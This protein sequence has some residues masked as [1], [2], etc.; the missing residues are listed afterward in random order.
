MEEREWIERAR[1]GDPQAFSALVEL[2]QSPVFNLCYRMLNNPSDADD[3]AQE[4]F[5]KAYR[6]LAKYDQ[7]RSFLTWLLSIAAHHCIDQLRRKRFQWISL[8]ALGHQPAESESPEA[9]VER[10]QRGR[11]LENALMALRPA[12]R[13]VIVLS[14]WYDLSQAEIGELLSVTPSAVKSRMHRAKRQLSAHYRAE[15]LAPAPAGGPGGRGN[16]QHTS[17]GSNET[18]QV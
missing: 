3:A 16:P 12:D 2:Y 9:A 1:G 13:A 7:R 5:I 6:G 4:A 10:R 18:V 15:E 11:R 17:E 8:E 14:Y